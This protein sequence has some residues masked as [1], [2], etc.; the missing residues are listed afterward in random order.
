MQDVIEVLDSEG[1]ILF[2]CSLS[3]RDRAFDY[4]REMEEMGIEVAIREPGLVESLGISLG[5]APHDRQALK[6]S[7]EKEIQSHD[8]GCCLKDS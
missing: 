5:M 6:D 1:Q 8:Y 2:T 4:A 3:Q 7:L